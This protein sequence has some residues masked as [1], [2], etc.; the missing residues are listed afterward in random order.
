MMG[1]NL[2]EAHVKFQLQNLSPQKTPNFFSITKKIPVFMHWQILLLI[3]WK[4]TQNSPSVFQRPK[5]PLSQNYKPKNILRTP[6]PP[7]IKRYSEWGP[8]ETNHACTHARTCTIF[9]QKIQK[10]LPASKDTH[11]KKNRV[12]KRAW[13]SDDFQLLKII[14]YVS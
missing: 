10:M 3:F 7:I 6:P 4:V 14:L 12:Y 13:F 9:S 11:T 2:K 8:W 1:E 5:Y